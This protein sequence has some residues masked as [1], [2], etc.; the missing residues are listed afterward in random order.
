MEKLMQKINIKHEF[1]V[2][3]HH[4][5][6]IS[7]KDTVPAPKHSSAHPRYHG[8]NNDSFMYSIHSTVKDEAPSQ[9]VE[10]VGAA[11]VISPRSVSN[12]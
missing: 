7:E 11:L 6:L 12:F 1:F 2:Q 10:D 9:L 5:P 4:A 8:L 3:R